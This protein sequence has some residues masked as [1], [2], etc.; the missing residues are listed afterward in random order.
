MRCF[1]K[2]KL[3]AWRKC[4]KIRFKNVVK[5]IKVIFPLL[6]NAIIFSLHT[7][8]FSARYCEVHKNIFFSSFQF[9]LRHKFIHKKNHR[10]DGLKY[11]GTFSSRNAHEYYS[12]EH[13]DELWAERSENETKMW[14]IMNEKYFLRSKKVHKSLE[15]HL[16]RAVN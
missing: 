9:T 1:D 12:N 3:I 2:I 13:M 8:F 4:K 7:I 5:F 15:L 10:R 11:I 16:C 6:S 14:E